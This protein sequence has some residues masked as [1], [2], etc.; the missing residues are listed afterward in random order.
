MR[1]RGGVTGYPNVT[2]PA[3][4]AGELPLGVSLIGKPRE[5]WL[6]VRLAATI[7]RARG[8]FPAPRFLPSIAE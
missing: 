4:L 1:Q 7:E 6:V 2:V 8:P 3:M 5:E